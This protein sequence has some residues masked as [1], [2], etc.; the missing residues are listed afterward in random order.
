MSISLTNRLRI[1]F[2]VLVALLALVSI[3][4]VGRL[5]QARQNF[6][7]DT[8]RYFNMQVQVERIRSAFVLQQSALAEAGPEARRRAALQRAAQAGSEAEAEARTLAGGNAQLETEL[9]FRADAED[10]WRAGVADRVLAGKAPAPGSEQRLAMGVA[11]AGDQLTA[12]VEQARADSRDHSQDETRRTV[13]VIGAGLGAALL[14]AILLFSG[15]VGTMREPLRRLVEGARSLA[16]G[17]LTTRVEGGGPVEIE[18]L[19]GAFNDMAVALEREA[20][21]RDRIE[22]MKDDFLLTVS[23]ELRTPVTSVKGFAELLAEQSGSMTAGQKEA[24]DAITTGAFDLSAIIDDLVDLARSDAGRLSIEAEP[25]AVKPLLE[26]VARQMRPQF[27][28]RGQKLRVSAPRELPRARVDPDRIVQVLTNLLANAN[29]YG[30]EGGTVRV[31][32][33]RRG[34]VIAIEVADDG[35]GLS[36]EA[37]DNVFERFWREDSSVTQRVGGSGLGLS[38]ARSLVELHGGEIRAE[39][40]EY[41]GA[42]FRFTVPATRRQASGHSPQPRQTASARR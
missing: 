3:L 36:K 22:R 31:S 40:N 12:G 32:A 24:I 21:E 10:A 11:Q 14:A 38:I 1:G 27:E 33:A 18:E 19:S 23:H 4:G 8:A 9:A 30:R 39:A 34:R 7:D 41:G 5:F 6:E 16:G 29:K 15:L 26:R 25:T 35:P 20:R 17:D 13:I 2:A 42:T 37:M 28:E